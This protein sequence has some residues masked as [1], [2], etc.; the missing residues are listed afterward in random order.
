MPTRRGAC[1]F[2]GDVHTCGE[3]AHTYDRRARL[4]GSAYASGLG[5]ARLQGRACTLAKRGGTHV[6]GRRTPM[7]GG[8]VCLQD[9]VCT[10]ARGDVHVLGGAHTP[11]GKA[12]LGCRG[13]HMEMEGR[14]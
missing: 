11:M 3:G 1:T 14:T 7:S 4:F 6:C 2:V 8:R 12:L 10:P 5:H 9:R 13:G